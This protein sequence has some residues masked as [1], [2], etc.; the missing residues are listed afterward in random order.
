MTGETIQSLFRLLRVEYHSM[1]IASLGAASNIGVAFTPRKSFFIEFG[2][3]YKL[4]ALSKSMN[5]EVTVNVVRGLRNLMSHVD[6]KGKDAS[7]PDL[8]T[9]LIKHLINDVEPSV[10]EQASATLCI[11]VDASVRTIDFAFAEDWVIMNAVIRQLLNSGTIAAQIQVCT[12]VAIMHLLAFNSI[13]SAVALAISEFRQ[14]TLFWGKHHDIILAP[15][16][17]R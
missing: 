14:E 11:L 9:L 8:T 17:Y 13:R 5:I 2:G 16:T 10:Q 3:R 15:F 12:C 4:I 7:V 6:Y 1:Q